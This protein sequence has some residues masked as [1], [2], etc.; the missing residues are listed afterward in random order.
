MNSQRPYRGAAALLKD[1]RICKL[2]TFLQSATCFSVLPSQH[3]VARL[4]RW[5]EPSFDRNQFS[6]HKFTR[7]VLVNPTNPHFDTRPPAENLDSHILMHICCGSPRYFCMTDI[8]KK[9]YN[10]VQW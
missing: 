9:V 2:D 1:A 3:V 8:Q 4:V 6:T 5:Y 10:V 7:K